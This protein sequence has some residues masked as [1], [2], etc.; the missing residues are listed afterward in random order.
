MYKR[1]LGVYASLTHLSAL[2]DHFAELGLE[3]PEAFNGTQK[4]Y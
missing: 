3:V 4:K 1:F 2:C